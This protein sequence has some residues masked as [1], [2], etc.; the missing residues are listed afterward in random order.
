MNRLFL[1]TGIAFFAATTFLLIIT[2]SLSSAYGCNNSTNT[3]HT[4]G[5]NGT[6]GNITKS[7]VTSPY[8]ISNVS[9]SFGNGFG[10]YNSGVNKTPCHSAGGGGGAGGG[11][12]GGGGGS[13]GAALSGG[14]GGGG[15]YAY[16]SA[17]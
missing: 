10:I 3:N 2:L 4:A 12:S 8:H 13:T 16:P 9:L 5:V 7:A 17:K 11:L 15:S 1:I 14:G 6:S